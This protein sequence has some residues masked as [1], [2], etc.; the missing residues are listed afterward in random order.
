MI[1]TVAVVGSGYMGGGIAQVLALSGRAV[2]LADVSAEHAARSRDRIIAEAHDFAGRGLFPADAGDIVAAAVTAADTIEDAV[3]GADFV[4]EAVPEILTIKHDILRRISA[5]APPAA[6]I[7]SNTS[8]IAISRLAEA[9]A[10]PSRFIGVHFSNPAPFIPGVEVIPHA[11]TAPD[12]AGDVIALLA[13]C[14]KT[15]VEIADVTGFVLN[16][17]QY[18]L[19]TE[20]SRLV[21][22][23]VADAQSIDLI[24]RTTFG[25]RLPFFGPFAIADMAGLDVYD[26]CY[27]SLSE[28]YPDRFAAP[29]ALTERVSR[30]EI[31]VKSG[32]GF[33][34][35]PPERAA[36]LVAYRDAAYRAMADL[37]RDVGPAPID[38]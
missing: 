9:V 29:A 36:A 3:S 21:E 5:A 11:A 32:R 26:F 38:Y 33:T 24:A 15:G 34:A 2:R 8:T 19:F 31:G 30:G 1:A 13:E 27:T 35:T 37:V 10:E 28:A 12:V 25:F 23:G 14:G 22:E 20:A 7:G 4:E 6:I 18:A 16:R 17:L